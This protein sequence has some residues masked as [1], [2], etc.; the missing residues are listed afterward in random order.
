[1]PAVNNVT[2]MLD[3]RKIGYTAFSLPDEKLGAH[4]TARLL[5][6]PPELVFKTIVVTR[7][8]PG[9]PLLVLV[10]G[11]ATVDLK[12]VAAAMGEK[13]VRLPTE[14]E[15]E[16]LTGLRAGGISPLALLKR[17]FRVLIDNS[18]QEHAEVHVS[19][20]QRGLNIR[21][22]VSDLARLANARFASVSAP[23]ANR[24]LDGDQSAT[25]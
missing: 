4:E 23:A 24:D 18:A 21:L 10:P 7:E 8:K 12:K 15:A 3:A 13:R 25:P 16:E 5:N 9:R 1:M 2:R 22:G 17:G 14:R 6:T 19:G 20:G 11:T